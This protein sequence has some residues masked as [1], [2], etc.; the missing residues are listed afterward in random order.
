MPTGIEGTLFELRLQGATYEDIAKAGGGIRATV[1]AT[2]ASIAPTPIA[3]CIPR[4]SVPS[5][6]AARPV[7]GLN[8]APSTSAAPS[9]GAIAYSAKAGT[10]TLPTHSPWKSGGQIRDGTSQRRG[11]PIKRSARRPRPSEPASQRPW[12][13]S[14]GSTES[15]PKN[16]S[17]H[18]G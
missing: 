14:I 18:G 9:H 2:R 13:S 12:A 1:A 4:R 11:R 6:R 17:V 16:G 3:I 10:S 8:T 5:H 15:A 7:Y